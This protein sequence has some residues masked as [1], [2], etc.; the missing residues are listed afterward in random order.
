MSRAIPPGRSLGLLAVVGLGGLAILRSPFGPA[1]TW[2]LVVTLAGL[3][4]G[5]YV[6]WQADVAYTTSAGIAC[7][8]LS[9]NWPNLGLPGILAPDRWLLLAAAAVVLLRGPGAA[10]RPRLRLQT[11]H[12]VLAAL[13]LY[14]AV[15]A[16]AA[17]T[18]A[19]NSGFFK[20]LERLGVVPFVVFFIAPAVFRT[21]AQR[22]VVMGT[23]VAVGGYLGL[24][25]VF[26]T[27][28]LNALVWPRYVVDPSLPDFNG[29]AQG[30]FLEPVTNGS[31][32]FVCAAACAIAYS[33]WR[34]QLGRAA[35]VAVLL[36]CA[37]G[38][39]MTLERSVWIGASLGAVAGLA[40][41]GQWRRLAAGAVVVA[42]LV[43]VSIAAVPGLQ[44]RAEAR[45]SNPMT[46]WDRQNLARAAVNMLEAR[47]VLGFGWNRFQTASLPYFVQDPD[48]PLTAGG[49]IVHNAPLT[50]ASELGLIGLTLW[51]LALALGVGRAAVQ[52]GPPE[53]GAWRAGIIALGLFNLVVANA[54][55]PQ[56]FVT[57]TLWLWAGILYPLPRR[58][59]RDVTVRALG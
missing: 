37:V 44:R 26:Q 58:R 45:R 48:F 4:A 57:L 43:G 50:Y 12:W 56:T 9:G 35:A 24:T 25:A 17:G 46:I 40:F 22:R 15:S 42:L 41:A 11:V 32:M 2:A 30:I 53:L 59:P 27:T 5:A 6:V 20:L 31:A 54:V 13:V 47:P 16:F 18:L 49:F 21:D 34:D 1:T 8:C 36:L 29:R 52:R 19:T 23:L 33:T 51:V 14:A 38:M 39:F 55:Y 7:A 3:A 28:G 10:D